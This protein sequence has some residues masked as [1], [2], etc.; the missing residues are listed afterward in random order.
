MDNNFIFDQVANSLENESKLLDLK[1]LQAGSMIFVEKIEHK[2]VRKFN[3][4]DEMEDGFFVVSRN[5]DNFFL[6]GRSK[7]KLLNAYN[8]GVLDIFNNMT[9]IYGG[10][11]KSQ[12]IFY[13]GKTVQE[14]ENKYH[15]SQE[16]VNQLQMVQPRTKESLHLQQQ[17]QQKKQQFLHQQQQ[18]STSYKK[19]N[20]ELPTAASAYQKLVETVTISSGEEGDEVNE[21]DEEEPEE[22]NPEEGVSVDVVDGNQYEDVKTVD[23]NGKK[24]KTRVKR[25]SADPSSK[26]SAKFSKKDIVDYLNK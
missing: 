3:N 8:S 6:P 5:S 18:P 13:M 15:N 1:S 17:E 16:N 9:M 22:V 4:P 2:L 20:I 19:S 12:H 7:V 25:K 14:A 10:V 21:V 26:K 24:Q 11:K 23:E